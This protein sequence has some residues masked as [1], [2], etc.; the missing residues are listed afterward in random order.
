MAEANYQVSTINGQGANPVPI[1]DYNPA[2]RYL[3]V[4]NV[5][6]GPAYVGDRDN[7][8]PLAGAGTRIR[9]G[10]RRSFATQSGMYA[11]TWAGT[12]Y[13]LEVLEQ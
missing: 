9:P 2:R 7:V 13:T 4:T 6:H 5:G 11:V 10:E 1:A 12:N 8:H 3:E